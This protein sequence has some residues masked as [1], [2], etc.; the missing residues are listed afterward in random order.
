MDKS[1]YQHLC[2]EAEAGRDA[3]VTHPATNEEGLVESC[4]MKSDHLVVRTNNGMKK[5]WD[6]HDCEDLNR[7]KIGPMVT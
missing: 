5:C 7:P 2:L 6:F 1:R 3:Y 4:I